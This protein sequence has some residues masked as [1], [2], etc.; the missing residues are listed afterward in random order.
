MESA[1]EGH[2]VVVRY[3]SE[4]GESEQTLLPAHLRTTNGLWYCE[5]YAYERRETR[6]YRVDRMLDVRGAL[7][8]A[9]VDEPEKGIIHLDP[10]APEVGIALTARG[11]LRL[12]REQ[13]LAKHVEVTATGDGRIRIRLRPAEYEWLLRILLDLGTEAH[14]EAPAE[15]RRALRQAAQAILDHHAER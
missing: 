8:P 13:H 14:V 5:A 3:R 9:E 12:E 4:N 7:P 1:R 6:I 11:V 2:W 10:A 15:V